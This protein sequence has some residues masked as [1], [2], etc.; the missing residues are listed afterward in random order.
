MSFF[1]QGLDTTSSLFLS[2]AP[3]SSL[4]NIRKKLCITGFALS[5]GS[6]ISVFADTGTVAQKF[7]GRIQEQVILF[8]YASATRGA[9]P[10][11]DLPKISGPNVYKNSSV[12][13]MYGL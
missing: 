7:S 8:A 12:P 13:N 6:E 10:D 4:P 9:S 11:I 5:K 3:G 1:M 2:G